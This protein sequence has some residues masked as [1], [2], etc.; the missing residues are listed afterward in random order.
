MSSST[1]G[2]KWCSCFSCLS[3]VP[4]AWDSYPL[5]F[6][7]FLFL[8][9][10]RQEANSCSAAASCFMVKI[11]KKA[12]SVCDLS[13]TPSSSSISWTSKRILLILEWSAM[14]KKD[15]SNPV[16]SFT[17]Y[18]PS[19]VL[20]SS[21]LTPASELTSILLYKL[22]NEHT[23]WINKAGFAPPFC[24]MAVMFPMWARPPLAWQSNCD[25]LWNSKRAVLESSRSVCSTT[26]ACTMPKS[27]SNLG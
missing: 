4:L 18:L 7:N 13:L 16:V 3:R 23:R 27:T 5:N 17:A 19:T 20:P 9:Q 6:F 24:R 26:R 11:A 14:F 2:V 12:P 10:V 25:H 22:I 1:K 15:F 8:S 21:L